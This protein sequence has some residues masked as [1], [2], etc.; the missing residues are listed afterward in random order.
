[1]KDQNKVCALDIRS[2]EYLE[3]KI[4]AEDGDWKRKTFHKELT[5][6]KKDIE[7]LPLQGILRK[8]YKQWTEAGMKL[9]MSTVVK[10][11]SFLTEKANEGKDNS[12][13]AWNREAAQFMEERGLNIWAIMTTW[14]TRTSKGKEF[15]RELCIQRTEGK[16]EDQ[17]VKRFKKGAAEELKL[18]VKEVETLGG[19]ERRKVWWQRDVSKSRKQVGP[20]LRKAMRDDEMGERA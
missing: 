13:D 17:A 12:K 7:G 4:R 3:S 10:P 1:M 8:D 2:A 15:R 14:S 6:A 11:L 9:G 18:E 16:A 19:M 5:K 20:L